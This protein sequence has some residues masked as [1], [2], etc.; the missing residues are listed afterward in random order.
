M[1]MSATEVDGKLLRVAAFLR[2][3]PAVRTNECIMAEKRVDVFKG[4]PLR[5]T[6]TLIN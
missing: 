1:G 3:S 5:K 4:T 6:I 2:K